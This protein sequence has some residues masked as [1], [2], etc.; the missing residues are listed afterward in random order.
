MV[1]SKGTKEVVGRTIVGGEA[2]VGRS[3]L[4]KALKEKSLAGVVGQTKCEEMDVGGSR[5]RR[6]SI[7]VGTK[8]WV[9][10]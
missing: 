10:W 5:I 3:E 1:C 6:L 2:V 7:G 9:R 4:G 8:T